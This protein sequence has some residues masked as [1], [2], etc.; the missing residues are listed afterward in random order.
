M[1]KL[2]GDYEDFVPHVV[3]ADELG[4]PFL[5]MLGRRVLF[6]NFE[7]SPDEFYCIVEGDEDSG[8][9]VPI[10]PL[11]FVYHRNGKESR[12]FD[13]RMISEYGKEFFRLCLMSLGIGNPFGMVIETD[14][15]GSIDLFYFGLRL[16]LNIGLG[17]GI[18]YS[19]GAIV[20]DDEL[21]FCYLH[22]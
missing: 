11:F 14:D 15:Y 20:V 13:L 18:G 7:E 12:Y 19:F 16:Y 8:A 2:F 5:V 6:M 3:E 10:L 4:F 21:E 9:D 22:V 1:G 17:D